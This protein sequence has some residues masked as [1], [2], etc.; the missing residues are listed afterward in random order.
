M[1]VTRDVVKDLLP[2]YLANE[3]SADTRR[4]VDEYLA[5]DPAL[6]AQVAAVR[7]AP[8]ALPATSAPAPSAEKRALEATRRRLRHRTSTLMMAILFTLAPFTTKFDGSGVTFI[9]WRDKPSIALA[10]WGT[11]AIM[12]I[13]H[14]WI[15][16]RTRV[17]G[18]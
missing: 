4:V 8:F 15:R 5:G 2:V 7:G 13:A 12:W 10:W 6:A 17:S 11:A 3:A 9:M 1:T 14:F 16:S 18:L